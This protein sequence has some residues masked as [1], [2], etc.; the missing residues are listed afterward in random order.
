MIVSQQWEALVVESTKSF[1]AMGVAITFRLTGNIWCDICWH[2]RGS[3]LLIAAPRCR[4]RSNAIEDSAHT[5]G[6]RTAEL[7]PRVVQ[8]LDFNTETLKSRPEAIGR[9]DS[10]SFRGRFAGA[11]IDLREHQ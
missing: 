11:L 4:R 10:P 2:R 5:Q 8:F 6:E 7:E 3:P 1:N 9:V